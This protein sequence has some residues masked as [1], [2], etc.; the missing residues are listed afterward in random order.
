MLAA[1]MVCF[2]LNAQII[3]GSFDDWE[4]CKPD[5]K[6]PVG[7]EPIGWTASNV[8]QMGIAGE[9]ITQDADRNANKN[10]YSVKMTS[11]FLGM[12]GIGANAPA[13]MTLGDMWVY[14]DIANISASDGG[15]TGGIA[16]TER[17]DSL[18]LY[19][20]RTLGSEKPN[21]PGR[22]LL[23]LWTGEYKS[24]IPTGTNT[25]KDATD[26]IKNILGKEDAKEG[27]TGKLIGSIEYDITEEQ[28]EWTRLSLPVEYASDENPEKLNIV[29][30]SNNFWNRSE[31]GK[32]NSLWIDDVS[33]VYNTK[34]QSITLDGEE[35]EDFDKNEFSYT[36]P[37]AF[38]NKELKATTDKGRIEI[39][40][41]TNEIGFVQKAITVTNNNNS[42][43]YT[44][45]FEGYDENGE[46]SK[47]EFPS[48]AIEFTYGDE[49]DNDKLDI[50]S[51]NST[52]PF[53]YRS[54][55][56][57]IITYDSKNDKLIIKNAG[58][59]EITAI[60]EDAD[61][62]VVDFSKPIPFTVKPAELS[63]SLAEGAWC[64][65]GVT[66]GLASKSKGKSDYKFVYTGFKNGDDESV[67]TTVPSITGPK[68]TGEV[69]GG[70][71]SI[72][73][74]NGKA[75]NYTLKFAENYSI[76]I[77]K[78]TIDVSVKYNKNEIKTLNPGVEKGLDEYKLEI[79]Y[80]GLVFNEKIEDILGTDLPEVSCNISSPND[81]GDSF[82]ITLTLPKGIFPDYTIRSTMPEGAALVVK[83]KP[84]FV[85]NILDK[86]Y[87]DPAFKP[88]ISIKIEDGE[89]EVPIEI[90]RIW[91]SNSYI[92]YDSK[93]NLV[94][95]KKI[96]ADVQ[97]K[98]VSEETDVYL[99][100]DT[101]IA[102]NITKALLTITVEDT[103]KY[104]GDAN[105]EFT[106]KYEGIAY[107][108]GEALGEIFTKLPSAT[109][110]ADESSPIGTY[111]II[112]DEGEVSN[113]DKAKNYEI[114][115]RNSILNVIEKPEEGVSVNFANDTN[116][117]V[118]AANGVLHLSGNTNNET[119]RIY[120]TLG[121]LL[122]STT[123][124]SAMF[125]NLP[126]NTIYIVNTSGKSF[127]VL[128]SK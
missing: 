79:S 114:T 30:S 112:I 26:Q 121:T 86:T 12:F 74:L 13:F 108:D 39:A 34:L 59:V 20:K 10:S 42:S 31:I 73:L 38:K 2:N 29:L 77:T 53:T 69:V 46:D 126:L 40:T 5:G 122:Q 61:G 87:G 25:F 88:S 75:T 6:T 33:L 65:R 16:F 66:F 41:I 60:Q 120:N 15:V 101:T 117:H 85:A 111:D 44:I 58:S 49:I 82:P 93:T 115:T 4:D 110:D 109:C 70:T 56:D 55:D 97:L 19:Y 98:V 102:F 123:K 37:Y 76:N 62:T 24:E 47:I 107:K 84:V 51:K 92:D 125:D 48:K 45:T 64:E 99:P 104:E 105:P 28:T 43:V 7:Q 22:I 23:A 27:S 128:L 11:K 119:V 57:N 83:K 81:F 113:T 21:E 8:S 9:F 36:F 103:S 80:S 127:K 91:A 17:P 72:K 67:V 14:A 32:D 96:G 54:S 118:Y 50:T 106:I 3:N 116:I 1:I 63:V 71:R 18:V 90:S 78:T 100:R 35:I 95:I 52:I 68:Q 94:S 124:E 89:N